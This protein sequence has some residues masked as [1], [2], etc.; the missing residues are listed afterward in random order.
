MKIIAVAIR[1]ADNNVVPDIL[2]AENVHKDYAEF[3]IESLNNYRS[4]AYFFVLE[5]D[6][7]I[8]R[9]VSNFAW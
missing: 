3:M 7:Y 9:G 1:D 6:N 8:L 2:I 4:S 5:H